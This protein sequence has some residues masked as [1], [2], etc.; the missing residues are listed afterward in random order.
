MI[1]KVSRQEPSE[2]VHSIIGKDTKQF[3][4]ALQY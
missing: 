4:N 1:N 2:L 3:S